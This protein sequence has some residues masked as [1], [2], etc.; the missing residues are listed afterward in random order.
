MKTSISII[1]FSLLLLSAPCIMASGKGQKSGPSTQSTISGVI[2]DTDSNEKLA[3]VTVRFADSDKKIFTDSKGEFTL[4]GLAPGTYK[5]KI[6]CISYKDKEISVKV[7]KSQ[8]E[9][10]T[11]QLNP[12]EP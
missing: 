2:K 8:E 12:I 3:G 7:S 5:L 1:L 11:V 6:N 10:V 4:E 9:K